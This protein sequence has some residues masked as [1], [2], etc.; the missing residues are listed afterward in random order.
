MQ[1][2]ASRSRVFHRMLD[3]G[4]FDAPELRQYTVEWFDCGLDFLFQFETL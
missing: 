2:L 1:E 3:T 4:N